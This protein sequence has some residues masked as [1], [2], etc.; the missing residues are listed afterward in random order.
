MTINITLDLEDGELD[1]Y[2]AELAAYNSANGTTLNEAEFGAAKLRAEAAARK[3]AAIA[4][5]AARMT[6]TARL[7]PDTS[8]EQLTG[9]ISSLIQSAVAAHAA[10][11]S[12]DAQQEFLDAVSNAQ[13]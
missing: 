4:D 12:G 3:Q 13:Q 8:R 2:Q 6:A 7:L 5:R 1:A 10:T 9:D 11:L